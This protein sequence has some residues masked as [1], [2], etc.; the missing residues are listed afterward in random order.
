MNDARI[1]PSRLSI[2]RG[3][4]GDAADLAAFGARTFLDT[5]GPA[6]DAAHIR[7][8]LDEAF[9]LA[10]Q[11]AELADPDT[12]VLL[13]MQG[14]TLVAYAQ[15]RRGP[16]P[17]CVAHRGAI[18]LQR[19]YLDRAIHG[20][21]VAST[22]MDAVRTVAVELG[23]G[24]VWLGVWEHNPRAIAFY[25]KCGYVDVGSKTFD[26]GPDRQVDR[27]MLAAIEGA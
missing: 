26:V 25:A 3:V 8:Y 7:A 19:F 5:F 16:A 13:A 18:E 12:T 1:D 22:L 9:G 6:N 2:R 21:G 23:A 17:V 10:Q 20:S 14:D 27:V 24:H 4:A 15:L 11:A